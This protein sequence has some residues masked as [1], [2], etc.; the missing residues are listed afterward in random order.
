MLAWGVRFIDGVSK[1]SGLIVAPVVLAYMGILIYEM[2]ARYIF[3][4]PTIWAHEISTFL[5]GAQFMLGG[6]YCYWAGAMV[7]VDV[8]HG[9]LR[10]RV[11]AVVDILLFTVTAGVLGAMAWYGLAIFVGSLR[12]LERSDSAFSPPLYPLRGV[13][14]LAALLFLL[15]AAG[16]L[17][18]DIH[19]AVTGRELK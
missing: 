4:S 9:R 7:S 12:L 16:K 8:V 1:W 13:I 6:A 17:V 10:G 14:P 15:Q 18:R 11:R 3:G 5:F 2:A 19:L